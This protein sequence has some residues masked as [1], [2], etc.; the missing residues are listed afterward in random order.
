[1]FGIKKNKKKCVHNITK[2]NTTI[3]IL[4]GF[5]T[6]VTPDV[7]QGVCTCCGRS[8]EFGKDNK[9]KK[10]GERSNADD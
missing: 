10:K 3:K 6:M 9:I 4:E 1:M 8:F 2:D 7:K 5:L